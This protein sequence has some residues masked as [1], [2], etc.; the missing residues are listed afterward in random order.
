MPEG[1]H[2]APRKPRSTLT[3]A[4]LGV[5][6]PGMILGLLALGVWQVE[7]LQWKVELIRQ[8]DARVHASAVPA[9]GPDR[10]PTVT[11]DSDQYRHV[12]LRG[13]FDNDRETLTQAVTDYGPGFW[14]MTPF[15]TDAGFTVLVNRGYV[16][17]DRRAPDSRAAGQIE[18]E[19]TVQGLLRITEPRGGFLRANDPAADS[20]R[21][22]DVAA[23][24]AKRGLTEVAPYF[25]DADATA[26]AGGWPKGGLTVIRFPNSHLV[27]ALTWFGLALML[28]AGG[29]F[30]AW[31]ERR[32]RRAFANGAA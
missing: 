16:P 15:R 32:V 4:I 11:R 2:E 29:A 31:D 17:T 28:A 20:W 27:Y 10:W 8:V 18:G 25:V 1:P 12:T 21:S 14:V 24:A 19:T 22:R 9:P 30:L 26:N 13:R 3:L 5:L 7:R 23:I 6:I